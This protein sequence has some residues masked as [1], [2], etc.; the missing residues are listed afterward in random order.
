MSKMRKG[1]AGEVIVISVFIMGLA[2]FGSVAVYSTKTSNVEYAKAGLQ[3][4]KIGANSYWQK[5]CN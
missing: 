3:E 4:C 5:E 2:I 1:S